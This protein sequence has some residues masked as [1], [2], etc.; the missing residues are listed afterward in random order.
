[1]ADEPNRRL[2]GAMAAELE[3]QAETHHLSIWPIKNDGIM[4]WEGPV[5]LFQLAQAVRTELENEN[6]ERQEK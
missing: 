2:V 3:K 6:K 4:W 5:N 1:M